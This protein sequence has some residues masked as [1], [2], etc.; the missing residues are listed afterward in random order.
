MKSLKYFFSSFL[1]KHRLIILYILIGI[2][3]RFLLMAFAIHHDLLCSA[4]RESLWVF[5]GVFQIPYFAELNLGIYMWIVKHFLTALPTNLAMQV[6]NTFS[7][8]P[9]SLAYFT[10]LKSKEVF[11]ELF[12]LKIPYLI[13]D[14]GLLAVIIKFFKGNKTMVLFWAINPFV[15]YNSYMWGRYGVLPILFAFLSWVIAGRKELKN[16]EVYSALLMGLAISYRISF[17]IFLPVLIIF[18][19]KNY[20]QFITLLIASTLPYLFTKWLINHLGGGR[21]VEEYIDIMFQAKIGSGFYSVS[22]F[23][24]SYLAIILFAIKDKLAGVFSYNKFIYFSSLSIL[25]YFAFAMF[26]PQYLAWITPA[27]LMII[28]FERRTIYLF[29]LLFV[30]FFLFSDAYFGCYTSVCLISE[31]I[32][33]SFASTFAS[34]KNQLDQVVSDATLFSLLHSVFIVILIAIA[35][36]A[37]KRVYENKL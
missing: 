25:A 21:G 1:P 20:R 9:D 7:V 23:V 17:V 24:V 22:L 33:T 11:R 16:F 15:L 12:L 13:C 3:V 27:A 34:F 36:I 37:S 29:L 30:V 5:K 2:F 18:L 10:F 32:S 19:S 8:T 28:Y 4:W 14:L 31:T 35:W 6:Q 26:Y